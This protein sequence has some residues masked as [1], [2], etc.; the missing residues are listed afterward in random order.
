MYTMRLTIIFLYSTMYKSYV[1]CFE[2]YKTFA[3]FT[4][5]IN[6]KL[7]HTLDYIYGKWLQCHW[8]S[9]VYHCIKSVLQRRLPNNATFLN[10]NA[11]PWTMTE[12]N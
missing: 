9:L 1:Y 7:F 12:T 8:A 2:K 4:L 5:N 10:C 11:M 3:W 6:L